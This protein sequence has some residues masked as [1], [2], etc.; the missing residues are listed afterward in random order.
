MASL[1]L[2]LNLPDTLAREAAET[3][4]LTSEALEKMLREEIRRRRVDELFAAADRLA[5][6]EKP[7]LTESDVEAEILAA[8]KKRRAVDAGCR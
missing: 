2:K 8:R 7:P 5:A 6:Q 4:P 3:G 1:E